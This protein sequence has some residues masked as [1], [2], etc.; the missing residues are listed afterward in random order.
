MDSLVPGYQKD[1]FPQFYGLVQ[2]GVQR[3]QVEDLAPPSLQTHLALV[4]GSSFL[5]QPSPDFYDQLDQAHGLGVPDVFLETWWKEQSFSSNQERF[6]SELLMFLSGVIYT[7]GPGSAH[8]AV[9]RPSVISIPSFS[10]S[11][12][13]EAPY[14]GKTTLYFPDSPPDRTEGQTMME[15]K[16]LLHEELMSVTKRSLLELAIAIYKQVYSRLIRRNDLEMAAQIWD[17][18]TRVEGMACL[19]DFISRM[20]NVEESSLAKHRE[21]LRSSFQR[22][23]SLMPSTSFS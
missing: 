1:F 7:L 10:N 12:Q 9:R 4:M 8:T 18:G 21:A 13:V 22:V 2:E 14:R 20:A 23:V 19:L 16:E 5:R 3:A 11:R 17:A 6:R 15:A